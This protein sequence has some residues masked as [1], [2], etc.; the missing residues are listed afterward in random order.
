MTIQGQG[1]LFKCGVATGL[2][3][4]SA[5]AR[6]ADSFNLV[7]TNENAVITACI[8]LME[9]PAPDMKSAL[10]EYSE[11]ITYT[12]YRDWQCLS[13][14]EHLIRVAGN[15]TRIDP[16]TTLTCIQ[17]NSKYSVDPQPMKSMAQWTMQV[18]LTLGQCTINGSSYNFNLAVQLLNELMSHHLHNPDH[19]QMA[20]KVWRKLRMQGYHPNRGQVMQLTQE[21]RLEQ[22]WKK[23]IDNLCKRNEQLVSSLT[24]EK[25]KLK[26]EKLKNQQLTSQLTNIEQEHEKEKRTLQNSLEEAVKY[27]K[28]VTECKKWHKTKRQRRVPLQLYPC[29]ICAQTDKSF[30]RLECGHL[31]CLECRAKVQLCPYCRSSNL[32]G[33]PV[34][35]T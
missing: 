17:C 34:F 32:E 16:D 23:Q 35:L 8:H 9:C 21:V 26:E 14:V 7:E 30:L 28:N 22:N 20:N 6:L 11:M 1:I 31:L 5:S 18:F 25:N 33:V 27:N 24:I 4:K 3:L 29:T 10:E 2:V 12:D 15:N 13:K 19:R